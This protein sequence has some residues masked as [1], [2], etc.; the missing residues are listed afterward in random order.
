MNNLKKT[1]TALNFINFG[2]FVGLVFRDTALGDYGL[3]VLH[4]LIAVIS[5]SVGV[6]LLRLL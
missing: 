4:A 2:L 1:F 5:L 6:A 3:A